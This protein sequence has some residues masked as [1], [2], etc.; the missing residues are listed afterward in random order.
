MPEPENRMLHDVAS[1]QQRMLRA[2]SERTNNWR[3]ISILGVIGW[4]VVVPA[5]AGVGLGLWLD[6]RWPEPF[7]WTVTLL[8]AGLMVGCVSAWFRIREDR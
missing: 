7:S 2:R 1:K 8:I 3:M 5:L 4:S 6:R